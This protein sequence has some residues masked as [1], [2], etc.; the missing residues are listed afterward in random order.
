VRK[1][2]ELS[3]LTAALPPTKPVLDIRQDGVYLPRQIIAAL[4]LRSSSLRSEWRAGRLRIVRR[5]GRNYLIGKDVLSWL[6][7]GELASPARRH[8]ANGA[9]AN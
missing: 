6:V 9:A 5:C 8:H 2:R 7:G 4:G 3:V 1:Q